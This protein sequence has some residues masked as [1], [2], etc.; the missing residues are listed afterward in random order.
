[1]GSNAIVLDFDASVKPFG[2]TSFCDLRAFEERI[3]YASSFANMSLLEN[4][5]QSLGSLHKIFFCGSGDFHH[6]SYSLAKLQPFE[7]LHIIVF[8]NHPDN[9]VLPFGIHCGSWVYHAAQ[10]PNVASI[11]VFG[12]TSQDINGINLIQNRLGILKSGKVKYFCLK[13]VSK[14]GIFLSGWGITQTSSL[15]G[16][17][18]RY[19]ADKDGAFYVSI[20]KDVLSADSVKTSWDQGVLKENELFECIDILGN[21]TVAADIYGDLSFYSY[22]SIAKN[23][24]RRFDG[25][26]DAIV[27]LEKE[28]ARHHELNKKLLELL[29]K[30]TA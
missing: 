12:I 18:K 16:S 24:L 11:A 17:L 9:M 19:I 25:E 26:D 29:A 6:V 7:K 5:L 8:D 30:N 27:N 22:K 23:I 15:A 21:R 3:R 1:M 13:P 20:D 4:E 2:E 28:Q 14:A 10:L